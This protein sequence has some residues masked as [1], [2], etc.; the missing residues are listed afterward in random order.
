MTDLKCTVKNCMY[1]CDDMCS[2]G[3]IMVAGKYAGSDKETNCDSFSQRREG[4]NPMKSSIEHP[5]R[6][7]SI[8]CEAGKC[9]YNSGY[10]CSA[11]HVDITGCTACDCKQTKCATFKEK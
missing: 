5:S 11:E 4:Y 8:D 10:R 3:D 6:T 2:K 1:N 9:Y 7:I